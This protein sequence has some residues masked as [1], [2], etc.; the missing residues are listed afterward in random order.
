MSEINKYL[1]AFGL[2]KTNVTNEEIRMIPLSYCDRG[3]TSGSG[4]TPRD[5]VE[6]LLVIGR[7]YTR[8]SRE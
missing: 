5:G 2:V 8:F 7:E 4:D 6:A 3:C 1:N